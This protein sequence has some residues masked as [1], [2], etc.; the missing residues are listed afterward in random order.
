MLLQQGHTGLQPVVRH[1]LGSAQNNRPRM[2]NL[3][4]EKFAEILHIHFAFLGV[5]HGNGTVN[6]HIHMGADSLHGFCHVGEDEPPGEEFEPGGYY[7]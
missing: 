4:V 6:A 7:G 2:F 5:H 1:I 3:V